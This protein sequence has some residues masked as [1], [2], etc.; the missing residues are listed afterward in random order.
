MTDLAN[1]F[2][3]IAEFEFSRNG[4]KVS[5]NGQHLLNSAIELRRLQQVEK[6]YRFLVEYD[7]HIFST[8]LCQQNK[9]GDSIESIIDKWIKEEK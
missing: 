1:L 9:T 6:R 7:R 3:T 5:M 2:E 4:G 8:I